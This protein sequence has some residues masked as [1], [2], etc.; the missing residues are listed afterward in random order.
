MS[1]SSIA[2]GVIVFTCWCLL[3]CAGSQSSIL[4]NTP[5][6]G[7]PAAPRYAQAQAWAAFPY[8]HSMADSLPKAYLPLVK[9]TTVDVFFVH[10]TTYTQ[11][12]AIAGKPYT[13]QY[14]NASLTNAAL[15]KQTDESTILNQASAFNAYRVFAPRY[16]QAHLQ[17]Y[18]LPD[19]VAKPFF[20]TAYTDIAA[21]FD[22]YLQHYNQGRPFIIAAHSQGT[23]HAARLIKEKLEGQPLGQKL[24]AAYLIGMPVPESYFKDIPLCFKPGST[25]C[26]VSWRTYK[27]GHLPPDT[28]SYTVANINPLTF[29]VDVPAASRRQNKGA[30]LWKFN[31]PRRF[32]VAAAVHQPVL[33]S[34]KPR[35]FGNVFFTRKNYHIGDIN[36]FWKNIR[37]NVM[38]RVQS[39]KLQQGLQGTL[40]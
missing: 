2:L 23:T 30:I 16:R 39:Y 36:L 9:D 10:P 32:N 15:N 17:A 4:T 22:Y 6:A 12:E 37:D 19:T 29:D 31:K 38:E 40:R 24:I 28:V 11:P 8:Q 18:Y 20:D 5:P 21:G 33:W 26:F 13:S 25:G 34:T 14:W 7:P 3:S 1:H 27:Q 35:F